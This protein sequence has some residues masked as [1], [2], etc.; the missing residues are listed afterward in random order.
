[1]VFSMIMPPLPLYGG[2][3]YATDTPVK[4]DYDFYSAN[5]I[6]RYDPCAAVCAPSGSTDGV[7]LEDSKETAEAVFK[8]LISTRLSSNSN[9][10]LNAFQAAG[11]LGNMYAESGVDPTA[12][13]SGQEYDEERAMGS[14]GGYAFGLVQWDGGRRA[15][16]LKYAKTQGKEWTDLAT[17]LTYLKKE[18]ENSEKKIIDD[19]TFAATNDPATAAV[20]IRVVFE[21]AG[22][23]H[24][25]TRQKA[26]TTFYNEFKNL[27]PGEIEFGS[28]GR[29]SFGAG[30]GDI[31]ET[32]IALAWPK[33]VNNGY[34][35]NK[36]E[37]Q[38]ALEETGVSK[39]GD[40]C[41]M[42]GNSC[43]AF[44]A[45]VMRYS[46]ADTEFPCCGANMQGN[47][48]NK[49]SDKYQAIGHITSTKNLQAGDILWRDGHIKIY[50]G[51]GRQADASHC[52]RT[53]SIAEQTY[54]DGF[55]YAFRSTSQ[56][57][58]VAASDAGATP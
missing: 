21:R 45:T 18:L 26:A 1:M 12:I 38:K 11:F 24:D 2:S 25:T 29:C 13:Q 9:K 34:F 42:G 44:V 39:L 4:C 47:Y 56:S 31:A 58:G 20:R 41:S 14:G 43:D 10:P 16:L 50:I 48:M 55:Y 17:Q 33:K 3:A 37:Y 40:S 5:D 28:G 19:P 49:N 30:N 6:V 15:G 27:A 52:Q 22:I 23:P 54:F 46:G 32:A 51:D 35:K 53:A 8:Y 36:P 57:K 7:T